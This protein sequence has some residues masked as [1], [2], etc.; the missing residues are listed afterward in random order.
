MLE[1]ILKYDLKTVTKPDDVRRV[2]ERLKAKGQK[3][4]YWQAFRWCCELQGREAGEPL[5]RDFEI[6]L[7]AYE[8]LLTVTTG[9]PKQAGPVKSSA[10]S[11]LSNAWKIGRPEKPKPSASRY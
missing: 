2:M 9:G 1:K 10:G 8:E 4:A 7:V 5:E 11:P 6:V 3:D